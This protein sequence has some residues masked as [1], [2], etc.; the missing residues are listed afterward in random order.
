MPPHPTL[1]EIIVPV[2]P[3]ARLRPEGYNYVQK[4][5]SKM[6]ATLMIDHLS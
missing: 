1:L 2:L 5:D 6:R 4:V 3:Q